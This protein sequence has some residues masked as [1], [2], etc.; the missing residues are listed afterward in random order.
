MEFVKCKGCEKKHSPKQACVFKSDPPT[1]TAGPNYCSSCEEKDL[2]IKLLTLN[3][4]TL[5]MN[6]EKIQLS[7]SAGRVD[8][9][10]YMK[11]YM[12]RRRAEE[13]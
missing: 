9:K 4:K 13:K 10:T 7:D 1:T 12:R 8:R 3:V 6:L 11:E 2:Q 5:T